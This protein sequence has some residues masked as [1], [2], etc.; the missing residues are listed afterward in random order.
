MD[1]T[2]KFFYQ[3]GTRLWINLHLN[4][5]NENYMGKESNKA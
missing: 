4:I 1:C 5:I 3:C 2:V